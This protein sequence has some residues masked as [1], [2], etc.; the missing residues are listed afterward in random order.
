MSS[1]ELLGLLLSFRLSFL[2]WK[3]S[4]GLV[5]PARVRDLNILGGA[6]S[7]PASSRSL[8]GD[9]LSISMDVI[10]L[11]RGRVGRLSEVSLGLVTGGGGK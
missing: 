11:I 6:A 2:S 9:S 8:S 1:F 4:L 3:R 5:T 10:D 7:G